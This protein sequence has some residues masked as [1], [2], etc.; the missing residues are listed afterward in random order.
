MP[1]I[2]PSTTSPEIKEPL[3]LTGVIFTKISL[4]GRRESI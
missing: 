4:R 1:T 3:I 2:T